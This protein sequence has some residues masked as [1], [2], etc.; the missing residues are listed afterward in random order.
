[1]KEHTSQVL[2]KAMLCGERLGV[3]PFKGKKDASRLGVT[4]RNY[5]VIGEKNKINGQM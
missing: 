2:S 4:T 1:M 3:L 5:P